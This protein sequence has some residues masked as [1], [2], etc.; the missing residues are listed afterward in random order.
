M[1][2]FFS[3]YQSGSSWLQ[4]KGHMYG[5][6]NLGNG[7]AEIHGVLNICLEIERRLELKINRN[8]SENWKWI[9]KADQW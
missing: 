2:I 5:A 1:L 4:A 7:K 6:H 3:F 9:M 8:P